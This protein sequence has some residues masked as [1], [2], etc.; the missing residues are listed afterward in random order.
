VDG[1][2]A[3]REGG[4]EVGVAAQVVA[5]AVDEYEFGF[6]GAV[7]LGGVLARWVLLRIRRLR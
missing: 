5:E 7:G 4:E 2:A 3:A 6:C 1:D